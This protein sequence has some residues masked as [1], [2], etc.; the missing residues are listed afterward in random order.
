MNKVPKKQ[1]SE[2]KVVYHDLSGGE[3][4]ATAACDFP[5][6]IQAIQERVRAAIR[7]TE[8]SYEASILDTPTTKKSFEKV[9]EVHYPSS[10]KNELQ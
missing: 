7:A 1:K 8:A 3:D 4:F 9:L 2:G 6:D 10:Q 5:E